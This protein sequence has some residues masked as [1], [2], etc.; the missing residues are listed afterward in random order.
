[1]RNYPS[2]KIFITLA[3]KINFAIFKELGHYIIEEKRNSKNLLDAKKSS[4]NRMFNFRFC[5]TNTAQNLTVNSEAP[6]GKPRGILQR[7]C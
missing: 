5:S 7:D 2:D 6:H 4:S 1:M 3:N